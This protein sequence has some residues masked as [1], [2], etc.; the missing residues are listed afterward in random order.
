MKKCPCTSLLQDFLHEYTVSFQITAP[1]F[2]HE[3]VFH[4]RR[5]SQTFFAV[6]WKC[7]YLEI[8]TSKQFCCN[9]TVF[10]TMISFIWKCRYLEVPLFGKN[11]L[12]VFLRYSLVNIFFLPLFGSAVIGR[13]QCTSKMNFL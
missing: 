2:G 10:V 7:R 11:H 12:Q 9:L 6:I 4:G 1:L 3:F 8:N 13:K 5:P